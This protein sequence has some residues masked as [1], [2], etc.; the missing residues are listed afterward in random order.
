M[1]AKFPGSH[2]PGRSEP[3][4]G[5]RGRIFRRRRR[6]AHEFPFPA[7]AADVHGAADGGSVPDH[8]HPRADAGDPRELPVGDVSAQ[9]RR[10][11]ARDGDRRR[12]RLHV[13]RLRDRSD[14][15]DQ[16]RDSPPA[17]AVAREQP[18]QDRAA[19]YPPLLHARHAGP[20]LRRRD[21]DGRQLLSRRSQRLPHP[22]AMEQRSQRRFFEGES[23]AA[24]SPD[25]DRSGISLR[26]DQR[27][28]PAEESLLASLVDA[29]RH[30]DAE[31]LSRLLARL[32]RVSPSGKC[33][34]AGLS[35]ALE[36]RDHPRGGESFAFLATGGT[37]SRALLRLCSRWKFSAAIVFPAIKKI[38]LPPD[39]GTARAFLVR[40]AIG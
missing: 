14:G 27:R 13:A 7:H 25:H 17:G 11:H 8:R 22:D 31:K 3:M 4:A 9:S 12:A 24:L 32:D 18:P 16:S 28:E 26:S 36:G 40:P 1:D 34:G 30:R 29:A 20:L 35:P 23:A 37:R 10:A 15:A 38:A 19:Q 33:Q 21:R 5:R 39:D 2:A 6:V